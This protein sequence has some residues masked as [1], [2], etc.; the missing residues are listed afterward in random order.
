MNVLV[1]VPRIWELLAGFKVLCKSK[2]WSTS[3]FEDS[4]NVGEEYHNF[5]WIRSLQPS[6]FEKIATL[7]KCILRRGL[8][9]E[10]V[11]VAYTAWLSPQPLPKKM[12]QM[13]AENHDLLEQNAVYDLSLAYE[14]K[15]VCWKLNRTESVVFREFEKF[16]EKKLGVELRETKFR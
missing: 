4:V 5:L 14:G 15:P 9:Y 12:M 11:D 3:E 2:G 7:H 8:S 1:D 13:L 10:L 6:T 16:L